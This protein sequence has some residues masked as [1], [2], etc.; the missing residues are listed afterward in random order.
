MSWSNYPPGVTGNEP[1]ITGEWPCIECDGYMEHDEDGPVLCPR[2]K[3]SGIEPEDFDLDYIEDLADSD[4][5]FVMKET[6]DYWFKYMRFNRELPD[7]RRYLHAA[8][9][10][11][12]R[13]KRGL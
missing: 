4:N 3:G 6:L 2:C 13:T 10:M 8:A 12:R 7:D 1:Q 9:K 5:V 11:W